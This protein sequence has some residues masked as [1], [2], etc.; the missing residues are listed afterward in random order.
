[1]L[2]FLIRLL[3]VLAV[4]NAAFNSLW[5][6]AAYTPILPIYEALTLAALLLPVLRRLERT[7]LA[8]RTA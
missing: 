6:A 2:R 8:R 1:M 5:A 4:L 7:A 3:I